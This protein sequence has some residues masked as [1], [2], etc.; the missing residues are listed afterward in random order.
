MSDLTRRTLLKAAGGAALGGALVGCPAIR[1]GIPEDYHRTKPPVPLDR[2]WQPGEQVHVR[3][4]CSE[5]A[6]GC[7]ITV[8]VYEGRAVKIDGNPDFPLNEGRLCLKGQAG[9]QNL[10]DPERVREPMRREMRDGVRTDSWVP[11]KWEEAQ[12]LVV[13]R[14][15][16][17][18]GSDP[19]RLALFTGPLEGSMRGLTARFMRAYGSP[20]VLTSGADGYEAVDEAWYLAHGT[21]EPFTYDLANA[22]MVVSFGGSILEG[23]RGGLHGIAGC[24]H[25]KSGRPGRRG[26]LV[27]IDPR[28]TLTGAKADEWLPI[29]PGTDALLALSVAH[30]LVKERLHDQPFVAEHVSGF[31]AFA[32]HVGDAALSPKAVAARV[33]LSARRIEELAREFAAR[34]PALAVCGRGVAARSNGTYSAF[35]I[36]ALNAL[37]GSINRPG[38]VVVQRSTPLRSLE[39]PAEALDDVARAALAR[40][41]TDL[42]AALA[43]SSHVSMFAGRQ[44]ARVDAALLYRLPGSLARPDCAGL[45]E[46]L[47]RTPF[48]VSFSSFWDDSTRHADLV[49][50]DHTSLEGHDDVHARGPGFPVYGVAQPAVC[51]VFDT[52][53]SGDVLLAVARG[54]GGSLAEAMP[55]PSYAACLEHV[56]GDLGPHADLQ[57]RGGWWETARQEDAV[58]QRRHDLELI[59]REQAAA[60]APAATAAPGAA[61]PPGEGILAAAAERAHSVIERLEG[62]IAERRAGLVR[63]WEEVFRGPTA[64]LELV[65][66]TLRRDLAAAAARRGVTT[67]ELLASLG[68]EA[69]GDA[70]LLPHHEA[71]REVGAQ[72]EFPLLLNPYRDPAHADRGSS[73]PWLRN[74]RSALLRR[75]MWERWVELHPTTAGALGVADGDLVRVISPAGA[76]EMWARLFA[77]ARPGMANL[78][79]GRASADDP[80]VNQLLGRV[81]DPLS[82]GPC[83]FATRV[84]IQKIEVEAK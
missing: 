44:D 27:H 63:P 14:L 26:K 4:M 1:R 32:R 76:V 6:G 17:V 15:A 3:S 37:V 30:V 19:G 34:R 64:R 51:P 10:Y 21:R 42:A 48:V 68:V 78:P 18:R 55:W 35:A 56:A 16:S 79:V 9:L 43:S 70:A 25:M 28:F 66:E 22:D 57:R 75:P 45:L 67:D 46:L 38:G 49:L 36:H 72:E 84:K 33:G 58:R 65:S 82:G 50:P 12:R 8:R 52:R 23:M 11:I 69:R 60:T 77:G 39:L 71:P 83:W 2:D 24:L 5:C 59:A 7:G 61:S 53:A 47:E 13:E 20:T 73:R 41:A 40:P 62:V 54:L 74:I 80:D 29:A 81:H 31:E